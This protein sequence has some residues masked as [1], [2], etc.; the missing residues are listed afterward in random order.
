[1]QVAA[2]TV[3]LLATLIA[4]ALVAQTTAH[5]VR[6][7]RLG[8]PDPGRHGD[9]AAR[10]RAMLVETLG[11][12]RMLRWSVVGAAHW[13]V[14]LGFGGLFFTLVEA[15]GELFSASFH[16]PWVLAT[17]APYEAFVELLAITTLLGILVLIAVRL[18][19][20]ARSGRGA[21]AGSPAR[22]CGRATTSSGRSSRSP[23]A[24]WG[25]AASA[26]R[27]TASARTGCRTGCRT[28]WCA[29]STGCR[30]MRCVRA[31]WR[32]RP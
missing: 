8:Q 32:S 6:V 3:S 2:V 21:R 14:F 25:C 23:P 9:W 24:C 19:L 20:L 31:S 18:R 30:R 11:H 12:T 5:L 29:R 13:F 22:G 10:T 1:M 27:L 16:F 15:Y 28:R 26:E 17:W 7:V 4:L